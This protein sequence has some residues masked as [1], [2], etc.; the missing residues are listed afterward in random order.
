MGFFKTLFTGKEDTEEKKNE[1][2]AQNS[3]DIFKYDGI[4]ALHIGKTDYAIACF[5]HALE[6]QEDT[7]IH[8]QYANA[9]LQKNDIS[10]ATEELEVI[11]QT[12]PE[13]KEIILTLAELY[14]Q[15]EQYEKIIEAC[16]TV[17][18]LDA[19][20]AAPHYIMAKMY[21]AKEDYINAIA[22]ATQAITKNTKYNEAYLLRA[23]VLFAMQQY[24]EAEV[25]IDVI[26]SQNPD[27][28]E[29][30]E[31]KAECCEAQ[32][33]IEEAK[34]HYNKV[35]ELNPFLTKAYIQLGGILTKEGKKEEAAMIVEEGMKLAPDEL[36][37]ITGEYTNIEEKMHNTYNSINPLN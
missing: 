8:R 29:F 37:G 14:Y 9:L 33:K 19:S 15:E 30:L 18:N 25:D 11:L 36:K 32:E 16:N 22:Q 13:N 4:Q 31:I 21:R 24:K 12:K 17:I 34:E 3:F 1:Q 23:Q 27:N 35:I 5:E 26:L 7:E 2:K 28:D 6:I 20:L 10:G